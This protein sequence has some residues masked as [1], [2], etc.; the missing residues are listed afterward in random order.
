LWGGGGQFINKTEEALLA[1]IEELQ[2]E[3]KN[4]QDPKKCIEIQD[5]IDENFLTLGMFYKTY[6]YGDKNK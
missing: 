6:V 1:R 4:C 3:L 5:I 2:I